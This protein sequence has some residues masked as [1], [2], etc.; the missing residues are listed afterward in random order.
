MRLIE[1]RDY[2]ILLQSTTTTTTNV[3]QTLLIVL[4]EKFV[5]HYLNFLDFGAI[6]KMIFF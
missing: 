2:L 6:F 4:S 5:L 3:T 1:L